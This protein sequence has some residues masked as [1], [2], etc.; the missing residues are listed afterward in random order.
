MRKSFSGIVLLFVATCT[1]PTE[2]DC[3]TTVLPTCTSGVDRY[4]DETCQSLSDAL[5]RAPAPIDPR[6][7]VLEVPTEAAVLSAA[8]PALFR[9]RTPL[10]TLRVPGHEPLLLHRPRSP[11]FWDHV[12]SWTTLLPE[13]HAHCL[14][15]T[16]LG[17]ALSFRA[18]G[19]TVLRV[20]QSAL[21]YTPDAI[22]WQVLRDAGTLELTI[23][24][25]R[26]RE[27]T[28]T[29]GPFASERPIR[30]TIR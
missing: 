15:Y 13:A 14:P 12:Q 1:P 21:T 2:P 26:F 19:R 30:F 17:F 8:T 29:E 4:S 6:G 9:W 27:N 18:N 23:V 20:E 28:I 5:G 22:S 16:G 11:T 7:A 24:T 3:T 10:T 25:T